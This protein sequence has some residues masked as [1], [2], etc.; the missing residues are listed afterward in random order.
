MTKHFFFFISLENQKDSSLSRSRSS[1][2]INQ[3]LFEKNMTV[4]ERE[5]TISFLIS[6]PGLPGLPDLNNNIKIE[7][8]E[9][10]RTNSRITLIDHSIMWTELSSYNILFFSG[11]PA[12]L[13]TSL[14]L[15]FLFSFFLL[16]YGSHSWA[17]LL[18][19]YINTSTSLYTTTSCP[20]LTPPPPFHPWAC[21]LLTSSLSPSSFSVSSS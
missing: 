3:S 8:W 14:S 13:T 15:V 20:E 2:E 17:Y 5:R 16:S 21:L 18:L 6:R 7:D 1:N 19:S 4:S 9:R 11:P 10:D 12:P